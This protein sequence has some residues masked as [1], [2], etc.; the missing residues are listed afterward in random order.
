MQQ[1]DFMKADGFSQYDLFINAYYGGGLP[2]KVPIQIDKITE[3]Q[4]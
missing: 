3:D 4:K 2:N 1:S